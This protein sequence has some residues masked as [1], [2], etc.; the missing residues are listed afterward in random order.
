ML[1]T[2]FAVPLLKILASRGPLARSLTTFLLL[3]LN[4]VGSDVH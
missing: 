1:D 4:L 2:E 3:S